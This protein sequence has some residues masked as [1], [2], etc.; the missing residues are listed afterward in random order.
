[1]T[2][3]HHGNATM[4]NSW[5]EEDEYGEYSCD[6]CDIPLEEDEVYTIKDFFGEGQDG[7]F[8]HD[9]YSRIIPD[10]DDDS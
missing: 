7:H 10:E 3:S 2:N 8:C 4:G 1:M 6:V 5:Y 9:H